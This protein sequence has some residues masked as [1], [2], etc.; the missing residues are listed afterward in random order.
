MDGIKK[1][2]RQ[3]V[4]TV[5]T[6]LYDIGREQ[7]GDGRTFDQYLQ[8]FAKTVQLNVPMVIFVD[9]KHESFVK[10]HRPKGCLTKL[11]LA[12]F[13]QAPCF[14]MMEKMRLILESWG[15]NKLY[16]FRTDL[17][18]KMPEYQVVIHSKFG[19]MQQAIN[20]NPFHSEIFIWLDAGSS[21]FW[22][23][24]TES[25]LDPTKP[26]PHTSWLLPI[27]NSNRVWI[28]RDAFFNCSF[29]PV[30]IGLSISSVNASTFAA[31]T[32]TMK[33]LCVMMHDFLQK[34]MLSKNRL[35]NEQ[36]ALS[37]LRTRHPELFCIVYDHIPG[38]LSWLPIYHC[39]LV[40][41]SFL[42]HPITNKN[43]LLT[44]SPI[45][46]TNTTHKHCIHCCR[47]CRH[48]H[49]HHHHPVS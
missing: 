28:Q 34:E 22:E 42:S 38:Y 10:T 6:A 45:N 39:G 18:M 48:H 37:I 44:P 47:H 49:H 25:K 36:V 32:S 2:N 46:T 21:R 14:G 15:N 27:K 4:V 24:K 3:N 5:V 43:V 11:V 7:R 29:G 17:A 26:W 33:R 23:F 31:N 19:W 1:I 30:A 12:P 9:P 20:E 8:W 13:I 40:L 41:A 16:P 35:D